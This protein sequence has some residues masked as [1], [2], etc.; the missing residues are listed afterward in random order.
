MFTCEFCEISDKTFSKEPFGQFLLCITTFRLLKKDV[1]HIFQ[2]VFSRLSLKTG[3]K[4]ELNIFNPVE[5]LHW[6]RLQNVLKTSWRFLE[7][8]FG[9]RLEDVLKSS[10]RCPEDILKRS[11]IRLED[12]F[13]RRLEDVFARRL[14]DVFKT[15]WRRFGKTSLKSSWKGLEDV[16][17]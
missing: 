5:H 6:R 11:S 4:S 7:H 13:A 16:L 15:S 2:W 12:A 3:K 17:K 9:R 8:N 1:R 10:W 14:E